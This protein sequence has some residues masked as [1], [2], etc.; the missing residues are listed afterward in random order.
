MTP[1]DLQPTQISSRI[2]TDITVSDLEDEL[3]D[4]APNT[5]RYL[6]TLAEVD[7]LREYAP[8]THY[9]IARELG[10]EI[11]PEDLGKLAFQVQSEVV[12]KASTLDAGIIQG[13]RDKGTVESKVYNLNRIANLLDVLGI[14]TQEYA[15][16]A[17]VLNSDDL[18]RILIETKLRFAK[19]LRVLPEWAAP[20]EV[21]T[22]IA[23]LTSEERNQFYYV[24]DILRLVGD[25][26]AA[27]ALYGSASKETDPKNFADYDNFL[28]VRDGSLE[29]I[30][31]NLTGKKFMHRDGKHIGFNVVEEST[32]ARVI[33][34]NHDSNEYLRFCRVLHGSAD[35]PVV[36]DEE[37]Q[38][39]GT[40]YAAIR[41]RSLKSACSWI[42]ANPELLLDKEELF[43]F[44]QKTPLFM[45]H[46]ALNATEG[47][48]DR[49]KDHLR[50]VLA[51]LGGEVLPHRPDA[52]Y[53]TEATYKAAVL[54]TKI[55]EKYY[56]GKK[57]ADGFVRGPEQLSF[58][59]EDEGLF[60]DL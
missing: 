44:F 53:I 11:E 22:R 36:L 27:I 50:E 54:A 48:A 24:E 4:I 29:R 43:N 9:R 32:F 56:V 21:I 26:V 6:W 34:M 57:F 38:E 16:P 49:P 14:D 17:D 47:I 33:R 7:F 10:W 20:V 18:D 35:F 41:L 60:V 28:V 1:L 51:E 52:K 23:D 8:S 40:S 46:T 3:K 39:R 15:L 19:M 2:V 25:D 13:R 45:V 55:I 59:D 30:Y 42:A 58:V 37:V 31:P 5:I 12:N